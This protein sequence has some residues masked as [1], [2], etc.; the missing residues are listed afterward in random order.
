ME[1]K[2]SDLKQ[3]R[4]NPTPNA[5][6]TLSLP[7]SKGGE[8]W[9][10]RAARPGY[11]FRCYKAMTEPATMG[12]RR[13]RLGCRQRPHEG[14][15]RRFAVAIGHQ[16]PRVLIRHQQPQQP[17]VQRMTGLE[18]LERTDQRMTEQVQI[19]DGV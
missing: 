14:D 11:T 6:N 10:L 12:A 8:I 7:W 16:F 15:R 4:T 5:T 18:G 9:P 2:G 13:L 17:V 19:A 1:E 3:N